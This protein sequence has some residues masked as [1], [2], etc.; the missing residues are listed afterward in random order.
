MY[1]L[2]TTD[3]GGEKRFVSSVSRCAWYSHV[4]FCLDS[5][6]CNPRRLIQLGALTR[7]DRRAAI[8]GDW[9]DVNQLE[10]KYGKKALGDIIKKGRE[11]MEDYKMELLLNGED[12]TEAVCVKYMDDDRDISQA[13]NFMALEPAKDETRSVK[14]FLNRLLGLPVRLQN[15]LFDLFQDRLKLVINA[16][17]ENGMFDAGA[18]DLR[19][20]VEVWRRKVIT[21]C[22]GM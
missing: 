2:V 11:A 14:Q 5:F 9:D 16:A 10:S 1:R 4:P 20:C 19:V 3:L 15:R 22:L 8:G 17:K 13:I 12:Y 7:G 18:A 21:L 6:V